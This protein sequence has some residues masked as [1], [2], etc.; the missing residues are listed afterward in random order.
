L[1]VEVGSDSEAPLFVQ[2]SLSEWLVLLIVEVG[3]SPL[4][5]GLTSLGAE[6]DLLVLVIVR[7]SN[8]EDSTLS[9]GEE[10]TSHVHDLHPS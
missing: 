6:L 4:L 7:S 2:V 9:V 8:L 10:F 1:D 5:A 3:N